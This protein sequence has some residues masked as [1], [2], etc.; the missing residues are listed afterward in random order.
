AIIKCA[1]ANF[2]SITSCLDRA[3]ATHELTTNPSVIRQASHVILPGVGSAEF[4]MWQLREYGLDKVIPTLTQPVLGVCL[5]M[6]ILGEY[7]EEGDVACL[8]IIPI[9]TLKI[10]GKP[11]LIV[12]HMGWDNVLTK[13]HDPLFDG[14]TSDDDFY[15][16]HGYA[17]ELQDP[18]T[19]AVCDYGLPLTAAVQKD[20]FRGVQFH[21][22]KSGAV[23]AK[24]IEN[25]LRISS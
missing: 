18:Y 17:M 11:D 3:G 10:K 9:Q 24:L 19:L 25:F 6:Q 12:P 2:T 21:P 15:F 13:R 5:G 22:E 14:I 1:G 16:V 4:G 23:G 20:N 7:S 8:G